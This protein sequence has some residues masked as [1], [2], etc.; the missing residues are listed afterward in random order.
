[1][2]DDELRTAYGRCRCV[3]YGPLDEDFGMVTVEAHLAGKPVVTTTD[4]GGVLELVADG[5][6]GLVVP[7]EP[8]A[9]AG[10]LGRLLAEPDLARSLG[11]RGRSA[12]RV[13]GWDAIV[14]RLLEVAG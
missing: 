6:T 4:S 14:D 2:S 5:D 8:A 3:F 13:L 7:P 9:I 1:V 12:A 11:D 10:A